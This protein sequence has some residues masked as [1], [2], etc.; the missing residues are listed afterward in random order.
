MTIAPDSVRT[1]WNNVFYVGAVAKKGV[2]TPEQSSRLTPTTSSSSIGQQEKPLESSI[3]HVVRGE[4]VEA[5]RV[6]EEDLRKVCNIV[7]FE[8]IV[9]IFY[10]QAF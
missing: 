7:G 2:S 1:N 8:G 5:L 3:D 10:V 6:R 9:Q 4:E